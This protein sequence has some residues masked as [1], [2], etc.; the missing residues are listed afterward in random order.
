M[1]PP[2]TSLTLHFVVNGED[3]HVACDPDQPLFEAMVLALTQSRNTGRP[4]LDWEIFAESGK[5]LD[6]LLP[7]RTFGARLTLFLCLAI[8]AGGAQSALARA[9]RLGAGAGAA[10]S[11]AETARPAG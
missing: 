8:G 5:R 3:V 2:H 9:R 4:P 6:P 10:V 7:A 11:R 1:A